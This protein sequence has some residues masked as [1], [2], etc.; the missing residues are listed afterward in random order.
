MPPGS[1]E[2]LIP[3]GERNRPQHP[4][5]PGTR[6]GHIGTHGMHR[7]RPSAT[8][9]LSAR[10]H[11]GDSLAPPFWLAT[12]G[13]S[14]RIAAACSKL[15]RPPGKQ[16]TNVFLAGKASDTL[17]RGRPPK[18]RVQLP[19]RGSGYA[20]I[21]AR[22]LQGPGAY[23]SSAMNSFTVFAGIRRSRCAS[24]PPSSSTGSH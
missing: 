19:A 4:I 24:G 22:R 20:A 15:K 12:V 5:L 1:Q 14:F 18:P 9:R 17:I 2:G 13:G 21:S 10:G 8:P 7:R 23:I 11:Q 16:P 6:E 3:R